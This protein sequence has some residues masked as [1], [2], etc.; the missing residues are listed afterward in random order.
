[1][2]GKKGIKRGMYWVAD[3]SAGHCLYARVFGKLF[4]FV[5][6]RNCNKFG[7]PRFRSLSALCTVTKD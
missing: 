1:M 4:R 2:R 3:L 7:V 5:I 6:R